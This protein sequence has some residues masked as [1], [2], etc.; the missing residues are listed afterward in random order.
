MSSLSD[1]GMKDKVKSAEGPPNKSLT[2]C[3]TIEH[4]ENI[5]VGQKEKLI[6]VNINIIEIR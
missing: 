5:G 1:E 6:G 4:F 2:Y 3:F